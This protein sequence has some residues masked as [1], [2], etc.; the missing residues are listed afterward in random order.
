[1]NQESNKMYPPFG[2]LEVDKTVGSPA[3]WLLGNLSLSWLVFH[4][5]PADA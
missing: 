3:S 1:M 4:L 5:F 2:T